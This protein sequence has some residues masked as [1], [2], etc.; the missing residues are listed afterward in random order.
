MV[1]EFKVGDR[2]LV[3]TYIKQEGTIIECINNLYK[4]KLDNPYR[5]YYLFA[6]DGYRDVDYVDYYAEDMELIVEL[7]NE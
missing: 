5:W 1:T 3:N 6:R 4:V 2:V 7:T